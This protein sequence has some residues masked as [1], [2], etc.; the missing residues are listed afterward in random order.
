MSKCDIQ[1]ALST[2]NDGILSIKFAED[3]CYLVVH[4]VT[5][6]KDYTAF[7]KTLPHNV[8]YIS[9]LEGGLSKSR[10]IALNNASADYIWIMDDD[11]LIAEDAKKH[12]AMLVGQY[13]TYALIAVEH[14]SEPNS[15]V[16]AAFGCR[17]INDI[18]A[19]RVSSIDMILNRNA[20]Q[21]LR[22]DE[23]FGLGAKYPT[24]EEYIF[25]CQLL[26]CGGRAV[27]SDLV[28][29][30]H[31]NLSSGFDFYSTPEKLIAKREMFKIANGT[32]KGMV[33]YYAFIIKKL[34]F[35][36]K[37][38]AFNNVWQSLF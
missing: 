7:I 34:N 24:G 16:S 38:N 8:E 25:I 10:N 3:F 17:D 5:N 20:I 35:L 33:Y 28:C 21:G 13:S 14:A 18:S 12:I 11:V 23:R 15:S 36:R 22:F 31:I 27:Q 29:G 37:K 19:A 26:R 4:Q 9:S 6:D 2:L 30:Y 1:I 32:V